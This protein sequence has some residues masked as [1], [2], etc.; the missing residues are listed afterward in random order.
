[1]V[2]HQAFKTIFD[3]LAFAGSLT[4]IGHRV[5]NFGDQMLIIVRQLPWPVTTIILSG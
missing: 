3:F 4:G 1:M 5:E 2:N